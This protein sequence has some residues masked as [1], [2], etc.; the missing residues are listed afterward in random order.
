[1]DSSS[2]VAVVKLMKVAAGVLGLGFACCELRKAHEEAQKGIVALHY[3][4]YATGNCVAISSAGLALTSKHCTFERSTTEA[5]QYVE[6]VATH[7]T[8][9]VAV[10]QLPRH[11][12]YHFLRV[13][14]SSRVQ[15]GE[16]VLMCGYG[17]RTFLCNSGFITDRNSDFLFASTLMVHGQS[18]GALL[19]SEG[20]VIGINKGHMP[21]TPEVRETDPFHAEPSF[22]VPAAQA[23]ELLEAC[24]EQTDQG[25]QVKA[26]PLFTR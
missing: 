5:D 19:N 20:E 8:K 12:K 1:M 22:F 4:K 17:Y 10:V 2:K 11:K 9:D 3:S 7:P 23:R 15:V 18:G 24:C 16:E 26:D 21:C 6:V 14:D 25:W 13:G